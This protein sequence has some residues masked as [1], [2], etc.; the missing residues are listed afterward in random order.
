MSM[1]WRMRVGD[2]R[3]SGVC[4]RA[5]TD[6]EWREREKARCV[7]G[8]GPARGWRTGGVCSLHVGLCDV[9]V[10]AVEAMAM[11]GVGAAEHRFET[12]ARSFDKSTDSAR[13]HPSRTGSRMKRATSPVSVI[14]ASS[15]ETGCAVNLPPRPAIFLGCAIQLVTLSCIWTFHSPLREC[16]SNRAACWEDPWSRIVLIHVAM[17]AFVWVYSLRTIQ[18]TAT[19]HPSIVDRLCS[20][21]PAVYA[22]LLALTW[23]SARLVAMATCCTAYGLTGMHRHNSGISASEVWLEVRKWFANAPWYYSFEAFY[24]LNMVLQL[25][26]VLGITSPA[27]LAVYERQPINALDA[28]AALL[29]VTFLT[30]EA[31]AKGQELSYQ[32]EK[33]RRARAGEP[34]GT[35]ALGF[36]ESG[37]WAYSRHPDQF[38]KLGMWWAYYLFGVAASGAWLNFTF[39]GPLALNL[40][41]VPPYASLDLTEVLSARKFPAYADY[42]SRVSRF[43]PWYPR[44]EQIGG[45]AQV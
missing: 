33:V 45:V 37:L 34:P 19:S 35:Y 36:V 39:V 3:G 12:V 4:G 23:P 43:V 26:V 14:P 6:S 29:F 1:G 28:L 13:V 38:A 18:S 42:Q 7:F 20:Y 31:V 30:I 41:F 11:R 8:K 27:A 15:V 5:G 21:L 2:G 16:L 40:L 24:Q 10:C 25:A 22:L 9:F 44:E 17:T 32:D